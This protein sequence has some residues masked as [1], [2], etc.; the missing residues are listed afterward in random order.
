MSAL[1]YSLLLLRVPHPPGGPG[2][3]T[4]SATWLAFDEPGQV[5]QV[6]AT[7]KDLP[8]PPE[9]REACTCMAFHSMSHFAEHSP[10]WTRWWQQTRTCHHPPR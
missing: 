6:V 1:F 9:V 4:L 8:P 2:H 10:R 7:D 3:I 5:D